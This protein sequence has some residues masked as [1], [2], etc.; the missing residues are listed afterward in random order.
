MTPERANAVIKTAKMDGKRTALFVSEETMVGRELLADLQLESRQNFTRGFMSNYGFN[1]TR[2]FF[3][4]VGSHSEITLIHLHTL[5]DMVWKAC[6][7]KSI[8]NSVQ[9]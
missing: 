2:F 8:I 6:L 3:I 9:F 1:Q 4:S 7:T 5:A